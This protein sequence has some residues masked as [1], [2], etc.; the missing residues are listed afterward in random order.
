MLHSGLHSTLHRGLHSTF[1]GGVGHWLHGL[2]L[3]ADRS[4]ANLNKD[5]VEL[6]NL[7]V[8]HDGLGDCDLLLR[9][10]LEVL[11]VLNP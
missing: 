1:Q 9:D 5:F 7:L 6:K 10:E 4:V 8:E 2:V 3:G 11:N